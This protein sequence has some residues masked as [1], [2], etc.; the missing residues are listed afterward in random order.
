MQLESTRTKCHVQFS[1]SVA[2]YHM[3]KQ[4]HRWTLTLIITGNKVWPNL[5]LYYVTSTIWLAIQD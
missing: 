3:M 1:K 5:W 2:V 4:S